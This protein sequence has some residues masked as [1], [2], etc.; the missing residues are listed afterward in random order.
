MQHTEPNRPRTTN[1]LRPSKPAER[2]VVPGLQSLC[3]GPDYLPVECSY[4]LKRWLQGCH[5]SRV[6]RQRLAMEPPYSSVRLFTPFCM[7]HNGSAC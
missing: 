4:D 6:K 2:T 5:T 1:T 7:A 3:F